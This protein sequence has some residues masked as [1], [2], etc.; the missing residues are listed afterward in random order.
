[1]RWS[2]PRTI[3]GRT[4]VAN[5]LLACSA[6][7]KR[8]RGRPLNAIVIRLKVMAP[9][10]ITGLV[11]IAVA[12]VL[13]PVAWTSSRMLWLVSFLLFVLGSVLF[14]TA[15]VTRRLEES[16][17]GSSGNCG[18]GSR[19]M[20]TDIHNYTGWRSGGRSETMDHSSGGESGGESGDA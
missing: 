18:P 1:M 17:S 10:E 16:E 9:R 8:Q 11:L 19:A 2:G 14:F 3:V 20:P 15:R 4:L 7:G 13:I 6:R 12:L 5:E